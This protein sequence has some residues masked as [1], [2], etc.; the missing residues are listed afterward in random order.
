MRHVWRCCPLRL[1]HLPNKNPSTY[2]K[3]MKSPKKLLYAGLALILLAFI[4]RYA[5][6]CALFYLLLLAGIALKSIFLV[7]S[8][9]TR[10]I[11][12]G[13]AL[14]MLLTGITL[15]IIAIVAR[16]LPSTAQ[17]SGY[18]LYAGI[19]LKL[20]SVFMF[21]AKKQSKSGANSLNNKC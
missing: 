12:P 7:H 11:V 20:L 10:R 5:E 18:F 17:Y 21:V 4:A 6:L 9:R 15:V 16:Q 13:P 19:F 1:P 8:V 3:K 2:F 14:A